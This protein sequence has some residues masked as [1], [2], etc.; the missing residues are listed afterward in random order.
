[1]NVEVPPAVGVPV[2]APVAAFKVSPVGREPPVTDH[3][4]GLVPPVTTGVAA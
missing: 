1:M 3:V 4:K 2:T